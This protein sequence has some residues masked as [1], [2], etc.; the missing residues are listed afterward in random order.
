MFWSVSWFVRRHYRKMRH[1]GGDFVAGEISERAATMTNLWERQW[2]AAE[3][4]AHEFKW[5]H[6]ERWVRLWSLPDG[7]R[8]ADGP[9]ESNE[10]LRRH[11]TVL[12][13]LLASSASESIHVIAEDFDFA[14]FAG[15]WTK[16]HL[17]G[18]W[19]WRQYLDAT[20]FE[21]GENSH[22]SYFWVA[23]IR[24]LD[25]LNELLRRGADEELSFIVTDNAMTWI[26]APYDGGADVILP[27][28]TLRDA[29]KQRHADWLSTRPDGL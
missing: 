2:P 28:A 9:E 20:K 24:Q 27:S 7:K 13:E 10:I 29:F 25:E 16:R 5:T 1:L 3:P 19:P 23:P 14:D 22:L 12:Q 8:Y 26:Y 15:G 17:P 21:P 4:V 11:K 6:N 18:S